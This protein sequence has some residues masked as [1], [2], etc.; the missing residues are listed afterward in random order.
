[1]AAG[2]TRLRV[3]MSYGSYPNSCGSAEYGEVEDYSLD[4]K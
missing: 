4:V 3:S 2:L 1:V